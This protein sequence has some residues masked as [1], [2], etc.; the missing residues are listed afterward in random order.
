MIE[1]SV[2]IISY[3]TREL[4]LECIDSVY[5]QTKSISYELIVVDNA[6]NDGSSQAIKENFPD[7]NLIAS[8]NNLGFANAN[9][10][11]SKQANGKYILLLNPD[12]VVLNRAIQKILSFASANP[13]HLIYGGRTLYGDH[14]LNHTSC[15]ARPTL[16]SYFCYASGLTSIFRRNRLF[17]P[18]SYGDWQRNSVREVDI[19]T[20]CFLMIEKQL[21]QHLNGFDPKFFMYGED[22]DLCLRAAK[23]GARPV[24]TP[25]ATII[26]YCG[27]SENIHADKMIKLFRAKEQ[28]VRRH[29]S[30]IPM[31]IGIALLRISVFLR[32]LICKVLNLLGLKIYYEKSNS[33]YEIWQRRSEWQTLSKPVKNF[34]N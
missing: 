25:D 9:N 8:K 7:I 2:I 14:S 20:G 23:K 30:P 15:W 28:L 32:A 31:R 26:H 11:A 18:E 33:W 27:A 1:V 29:W 22:A 5:E 19:V 6:S 24:I 3:N 34:P 12:T 21:W 13:H 10:L 16:W 17:D 4:T